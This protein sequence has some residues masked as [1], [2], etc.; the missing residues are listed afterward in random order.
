MALRDEPIR[1]HAYGERLLDRVLLGDHC[2]R[3]QRSLD[4]AFRFVCWNIERGVKWKE[5]L[6]ALKGPLNADVYALQEVE[7]GTRRVAGLNIAD[8]LGSELN[9]DY[10]FATEFVKLPSGIRRHT[11]LHGQLV[12]APMHPADLRVLR[13]SRQHRNWRIRFKPRLRVLGPRIG[14]RIA[15][16]TEFDSGPHSL[17]IYN[18]HLESRSDEHGRACHVSEIIADCERHYGS[19]KPIIIAGDLNTMAGSSS[20]LVTLLL[21]NGF[22][23]AFDRSDSDVV[24]RPDHKQRVDWVFVRNLYVRSRNVLPL[25]YSDHLPLLVELAFR[26]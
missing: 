1:F 23:D 15:L 16:V 18:T 14:G 3:A 12:L 20:P 22:T 13:F 25:P 2:T 5:I 8:I 11:G 7:I 19:D 9:L 6:T 17:V 26:D 21:H 24:T 10:V 4:D